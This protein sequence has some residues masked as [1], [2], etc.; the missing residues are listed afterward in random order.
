M[1]ARTGRE[2]HWTADRKVLVGA[3]AI[4]LV[5]ELAALVVSIKWGAPVGMAALISSVLMIGAFASAG[6]GLGFV[7]GYAQG[8]ADTIRR[9]P[10]RW[11]PR[12]VEFT[13]SAGETRRI[14]VQEGTA[15]GTRLRPYRVIE[16]FDEGDEETGSLAFPPARGQER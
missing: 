4:A 16:W 1:R 8:A 10:R 7:G 3:F 6:I 12:V 5:L 15:E 2:K 11:Y 14:N 9:R 13:D